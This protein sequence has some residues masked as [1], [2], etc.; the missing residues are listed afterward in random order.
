MAEN[1]FLLF[2]MF[3]LQAI[4]IYIQYISNN[5][6]LQKKNPLIG[7]FFKHLLCAMYHS[8]YLLLVC[9]FWQPCILGAPIKGE[10]RDGGNE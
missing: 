1:L 3:E 10:C 7:E 2:E 8:R 9:Q 5:T 4:H 6:V